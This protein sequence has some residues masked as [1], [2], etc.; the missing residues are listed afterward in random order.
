MIRLDRVNTH[1]DS[2]VPAGVWLLYGE[3]LKAMPGD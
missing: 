1:V 3:I 2:K